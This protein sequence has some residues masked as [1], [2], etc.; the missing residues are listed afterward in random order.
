MFLDCCHYL[1]IYGI[2]AAW[3][4]GRFSHLY[5]LMLTMCFLSTIACF[6]CCNCV[7]FLC[8]LTHSNVNTPLLYQISATWSNHEGSLLLWY[9]LL[10]FCGLWLRCSQGTSHT[11]SVLCVV[12]GFVVCCTSNPFLKTQ[13]VWFDSLA[14]LNPVLQDPVLAIHPPC[15]FMGYVASA[16]TFV[17]CSKVANDQKVWLVCRWQEWWHTIRLWIGISW[18]TTTMGLFLGS[19]WAYHELGWGGWWFWDPV[20]NASLMPWLLATASVHS[21][22][23]PRLNGWTRFLSQSTFLLSILGTLFIRSGLIASVHSFSQLDVELS[24]YLRGILLVCFCAIIVHKMTQTHNTL[25][26]SYRKTLFTPHCVVYDT[27]GIIKGE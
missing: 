21:I 11:H 19:W 27:N 3:C 17:L 24:D 10:C 2:C 20:E 22:L 25:T 18:T 13:F 8:I 23:F 9:W 7:V 16:Q 26:Q 15:I 4:E 12:F 1:L 6:M 5:S 14:E